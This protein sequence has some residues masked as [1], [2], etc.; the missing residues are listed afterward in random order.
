ME[1]KVQTTKVNTHIETKPRLFFIDNLRWL[2]IVLVVLIHI[3]VTY[4]GIGGWY[5]TEQ[6]VNNLDTVSKLV[7]G[8]FSM[9]NQAYFMGFM[10][11]I[12]GYF[13]PYA[14][15]RKGTVKFIK[16]RLFRLGIPTL[17]YIL[18]INPFILYFLLGSYSEI[19]S[20]PLT[21]F[22]SNYI[23]SLYFIGGTG[24]LWFTLAL[25]VFSIVYAFIRCFGVQ[26]L[27]SEHSGYFSGNILVVLVISF[28]T[29]LNFIVRL[30]SPFGTSFYNMQFCFFAQ[31]IVFYILGIIFY[32]KNLLMNI[33]Y[34]FGIGWFKFSV[35]FG[36]I[37]WIIIILAGGALHGNEAAYFGGLR[38]QSAA[39]SLWEQ[40]YS[41]GMCL[42]LIVIFRSKFNYKGILTGIL[43]E[44]SFG[45]YVF[46][47]P[48]LIFI[49]ILLK[50]LSLYPL[51]KAFIVAI[52]T[53]PLCFAFSYTIRKVP[54]L[55]KL[56]S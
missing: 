15:D 40:I 47:A 20:E 36:F 31:Y 21:V 50:N 34:K 45:V 55:K 4:S 17:F 35:F 33:S 39:Y 16:D 48:I 19:S 2:M 28:I 22:Y 38:W 6:K 54:L 44:N 1:G 9:F 23:C 42:G 30:Y 32:R 13:A 24:P 56:F 29:I 11:F 27:N 10:F 8:I 26:A 7:S 41:A 52:I 12:A 49:S 37:F 14:Y 51:L 43:S 25:L 18:V 5:Y 46:H 53:L 3:N